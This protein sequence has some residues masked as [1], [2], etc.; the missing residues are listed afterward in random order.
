[1][2]KKRYLNLIRITSLLHH[3]LIAYFVKIVVVYLLANN[4]TPWVAVSVPVVLE[5]SRMISRAFKS[6]MR[7]ALK[8]NYKKIHIFHFVSFTLLAVAASQCTSVYGIYFFTII[9]G[10]ITGIK[11]S[12]VTKLSTSNKEYESYCLIEDERFSII[13]TTLGYIV[14]QFVYD[15]SPE[16]YIVCY[17]IV[18]IIGIII[19][20]FVKNVPTGDSMI[21][22]E[23]C[24]EL[25]KDDKKKGFIIS[26]LFGI[27]AG[28]WCMGLSALDELAP[29][30][31][32][33]VG[34]LTSVYTVVEFCCLFIITG[35]ILAKIK[36]KKKLLLVETVI[37]CVDCLCLLISSLF[38]SWIG[39][40]ISFALSGM[41]STLGDPIWASIISE[42]SMNNRKKYALINRVYF[43]TRSV[44]TVL[45]WGV[46]RWCVI[47]GLEY[48][49]YL[50][51]ALIVLL[52]IL[53]LIANKVNKKVFGSTI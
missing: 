19:S 11:G 36:K 20:M 38:M 2:E 15:I 33:K 37:A 8:V 22:F 44:A 18:G 42:Y 16:L 6:V 43:I 28:F 48:F 52:I 23:E 21:S 53:Y 24:D 7:I 3:F 32:D 1:M 34:Y 9:A 4:V 49:R 31:S 40:I 13:G 45:S 35:A 26:L 50:A 30:I 5:F 39:L 10:F 46:C 17:F 12:S 41:F 29:L 47:N 14:S 27:I 51:I 25:S